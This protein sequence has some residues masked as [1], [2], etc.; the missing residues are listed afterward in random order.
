MCGISLRGDERRRTIFA[1]VFLKDP[2]TLRKLLGTGIVIVG[3]C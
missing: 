3:L 2:L 1:A